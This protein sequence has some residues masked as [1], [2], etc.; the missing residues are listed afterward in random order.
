LLLAFAKVP[1]L[2]CQIRQ[3]STDKSWVVAGGFYAQEKLY[4]VVGKSGPKQEFSG[5]NN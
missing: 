2:I 4:S 1:A 5:L 3:T